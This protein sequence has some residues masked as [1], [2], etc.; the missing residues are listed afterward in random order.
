MANSL[1]GRGAAGGRRALRHA[2]R[3][4]AQHIAECCSRW[5]ASTR[6]LLFTHLAA[7]G[8]DRRAR[9]WGSGEGENCQRC[10]SASIVNCHKGDGVFTA[11]CHFAYIA[12]N[13]GGLWITRESPV[14][15]FKTRLLSPHRPDAITSEATHKRAR[16][17][18]VHAGGDTVV[19]LSPKSSDGKAFT[20]QHALTRNFSF[21]G[22]QARQKTMQ[23]FDPTRWPDPT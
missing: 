19:S 22:V 14:N 2:H 16:S 1:R 6:P 4:N 20:A 9:P 13:R 17:G 18:I 23:K 15:K 21:S 12:P 8:C 11:I 7:A 3:R 10:W 5:L